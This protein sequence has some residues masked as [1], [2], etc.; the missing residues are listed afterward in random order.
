MPQPDCQVIAGFHAVRS[1]VKHHPEAVVDLLFSEKRKDRRRLE[2][3][4]LARQLGVGF[5]EVDKTSLNEMARGT[6]HQGVVALIDSSVFRFRSSAELP[7][8]LDSLEHAPLILVLDGLEDPHNLGAC[9]RSAGAAGVD[10]VILP[11]RR[12]SG[13]TETAVRVASGAVGQLTIFEVGNLSRCLDSLRERDIWLV[14]AEERGSESLYDLNL[15]FG[16]V[17]IFGAEGTG[18]RRLTREKCDHLVRI[19]T[20]GA[21]SSLNVSVAVGVCLFEAKRQRGSTGND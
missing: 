12:G 14:G 6:K 2:L 20:Y 17:L 4:R 7:E 15:N 1:V 13:L 19:P 18:L 10:A 9:L 11:R 3:E 5:Q 16:T 8:L 21:V